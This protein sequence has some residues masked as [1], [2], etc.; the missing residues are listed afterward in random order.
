M[1]VPFFAFLWL[2]LFGAAIQRVAGPTYRG[3]SLDI[4]VSEVVVFSVV[5]GSL[6]IG[7][8]I[9]ILAQIRRDKQRVT[10]SDVWV[11][12]CPPLR[13]VRRCRAMGD[14][15]WFP[16][17]GWQETNRE[18]QQKLERFF[19]VPM[20]AV[21]LLILPVLIVEHYWGDSLKQH[22]H[23]WTLI[24]LD[25]CTVVIWVAFAT[26]FIVMCA[27]AQNKL[28]YCKAHW[29]DLAIILLPLISFA[30]ALRLAGLSRLAR[31]GRISR[32]YRLR[33]LA[34][35]GFRAF[36]LIDVI[37][38]LIGRTP[39]KELERLQGLLEVKQMEVEDLRQQIASLEAR[40]AAKNAARVSL[41]ATC[42]K[43]AAS[44]Q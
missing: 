14:R 32:A 34:I 24:L 37:S 3:H 4:S 16:V 18:L 35:R 17:V 15:I 25:T 10:T 11:C 44:N 42:E 1:P 41:N 26:E 39:E 9:E 7:I 12:L 8:A 21:A 20:I 40:I 27:V 43:S 6:W 19:S 31:F 23:V 5:L 30:R 22:E 33:S 28:N 13:M 36:L 38:R 2:V 29:L